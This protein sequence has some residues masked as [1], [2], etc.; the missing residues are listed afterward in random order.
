M[1]FFA[2]PSGHAY[3][4]QD[5]S[6][7]D[8]IAKTDMECIQSFL[9]KLEA[10]PIASQVFDTKKDENS[11]HGLTISIGSTPSLFHHKSPTETP[12]W[13]DFCQRHANDEILFELHPGNYTMYDRQQLYTQ[14]C[15]SVEDIAGRV[16]TRVIGHYNDQ[17]RP[18]TIMMDAGA[19][20]LTKEATPQGGMAAIDNSKI[21][22]QVV[23]VYKMS[24]EVSMA[25]SKEPATTSTT[26]VN[27][28]EECPLGSLVNLLPN[29]SCLSAACF[30]K[31][32]IIDDPTCQFAPDAVI[33]D[34]W[35]PVKGW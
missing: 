13:K 15:A 1:N 32:Y 10:S 11:Y 27:L 18:N 8:Q 4:I 2:R 29:H 35:E 20:A 6:A 3:D 22:D 21:N 12:W 9:E 14:A 17:H 26:S 23:E 31:Y 24:Q 19:T 30:D 33:V 16:L 5:Q 28:L 25:R 7:L 34:E